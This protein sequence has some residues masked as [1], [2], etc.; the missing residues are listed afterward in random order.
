ML[1]QRGMNQAAP[2]VFPDALDVIYEP[3]EQSNLL[4]C[5][6]LLSPPPAKRLLF[7][8]DHRNLPAMT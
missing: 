8:S 1:Q 4:T 2:E 7:L 6:S 5:G 3:E